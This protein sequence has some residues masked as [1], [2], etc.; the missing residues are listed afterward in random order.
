MISAS[1]GTKTASIRKM[2]RELAERPDR[3]VDRQ[4][5]RRTAFQLYIEKEI[6]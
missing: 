3:N 5:D 1:C 4:T 6:E 2:V